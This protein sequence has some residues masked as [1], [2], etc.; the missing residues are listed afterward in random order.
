[1]RDTIEDVRGQLITAIKKDQIVLP[2]LPEIALQ[3]REAANDDNIS[4]KALGD[5]IGT[6]A[7]LSAR[8]IKVAN[9]PLVRSPQ[10][11]ENLPAAISRLGIAY[12]CNLAVGLAMQQ[13]FQATNDMIDSRMRQVWSHS[14]EVAAI[15]NVLA[16]HYTRL[17][18]DQATLAGLIHQIG[19]LP[20][21]TFA[22]EK[23]IF[24]EQ[25]ESAD[26]DEL[27]DS[28]HPQIGELIL[29]TWSFSDSLSHVPSEHLRIHRNSEKVD[30]A[31][32]VIVA[33]LQSY[34]ETDHPLAQVDWNTVPAF[35]KL[36]LSADMDSLE[37]EDLSD[38]MEAAMKALQ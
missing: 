37:G 2:T 34:A 22:E 11:I 7:A 13:M 30:Y 27:I 3:V 18:P 8:V 38:E 5:L 31:D 35:A 16:R 20:I 32:I 21:L 4:I 29:R 26:L 9:S 10:A 1:M 12:S 14:S 17:P 28:L 25:D 15:S 23:E 24:L 6:D 19:I 36:G 33:K